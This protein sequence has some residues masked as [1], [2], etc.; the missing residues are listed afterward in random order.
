MLEDIL[1][2]VKARFPE[3]ETIEL[4][5]CAEDYERIQLLERYGAVKLDFEDERRRMVLS[6]EKVEHT[7]QSYHVV[8]VDKEDTV[9][10]EKLAKTYQYVW[11]E[12]SYVPSGKVVSNMLSKE[13]G[14]I[15]AWAVLDAEEKCVAYT[16][17]FIDG[18]KEYVYLYPVAVR[19]EYLDDGVL[20]ILLA[21]VK[22]G[23]FY[24][25]IKY[26]VINAW[27]KKQENDIFAKKGANEW[28]KE[29]IYQ[30]PVKPQ[31]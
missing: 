10:C 27:Y 8:K 5:A 28:K 9:L 29:Y 30:I 14:E 13:S 1:G 18:E 19:Q 15:M 25:N 24:K 11:P 26:I 6:E 22:N 31:S 17:G 23:L 2:D 3:K 4:T 16:M 21:T 7:E 20:E 12:S